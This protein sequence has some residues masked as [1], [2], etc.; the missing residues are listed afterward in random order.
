MAHN[1]IRMFPV[2]ELLSRERK[3]GL[4]LTDN[5]SLVYPP[6]H[7]ELS[8][9]PYDKDKKDKFWQFVKDVARNG[10]LLKRLFV[11]LIGPGGAGKTTLLNRVFLKQDHHFFASML[12]RYILL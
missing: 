10:Q 6:E 3:L 4:Q 7:L 5:K 11:I 2:D 12:Y 9:E 1:K 8:D